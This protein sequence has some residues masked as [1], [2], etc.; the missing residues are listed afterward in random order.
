MKQSRRASA[1]NAIVRAFLQTYPQELDTFERW[2]AGLRD[3]AQGIDDGRARKWADRHERFGLFS[4]DGIQTFAERTVEAALT[5]ERRLDRHFEDAGLVG[6]SL[7]SRFLE[8]ASALALKRVEAR[9]RQEPAQGESELDRLLSIPIGR[10][11]SWRFPQQRALVATTLL[12]PFVRSD[13]PEGLLLKIEQFLNHHFKDPRIHPAHWSGVDDSCVAVMK[14]WLAG[15]SF[16][17]FF[18]ILARTADRKDHWRERR[19]FWESYLQRGFIQEAWIILGEDAQR[20][21]QKA[22][23]HQHLAFGALQAGDGAQKS[24]SVLLMR[25]GGPQGEAVVT[26]WS[27]NGMCR[28]WYRGKQSQPAFYKPRYGRYDLIRQPSSEISHHLRWQGRLSTEL[29][30]HTGIA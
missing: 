25:V 3:L 4:T 15:K 23:R 20:F 26:E 1:L 7:S 27:H 21:S 12:R 19:K 24:H 30:R 17:L 18:E 16:D 2:C 22:V 29:L 10:D 14:R 9:L 8:M 13:P 28:L 6:L 5:N 11:G